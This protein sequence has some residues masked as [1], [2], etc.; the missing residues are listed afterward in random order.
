[1]SP[2]SDCYIFYNYFK[3]VSKGINWRLRMFPLSK[4][5]YENF[6]TCRVAQFGIIYYNKVDLS[7]N[8]AYTRSLTTYK[9]R[10][11]F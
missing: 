11:I 8:G 7:K 3:T 4:L 6:E 10:I 1:M 5:S 9:Q 2:N